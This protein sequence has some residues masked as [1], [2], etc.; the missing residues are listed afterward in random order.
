MTMIRLDAATLAQFQSASGPV[1]LCDEAGQPVR[2]CVL[3]AVPTS[4]PQLTDAEWERR[5]K[6][7]GGLTTAQV[8]ER[9]RGLTP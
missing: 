4:E 8:L 7:P 1:V 2:M 5:A 3:P 6:A 9:M